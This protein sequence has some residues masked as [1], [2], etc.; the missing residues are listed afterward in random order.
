MRI[1]DILQLGLSNLWRTKLRTML[2]TLGV[3]IGI[4]A[5]ISMVSF[6]T[7]MQKNVTS[8]FYDND[9][10]TSLRVLPMK[11]DINRALSGDV[12]SAMGAM[13][14]SRTIDDSVLC[15]LGNMPEVSIVYPEISFSVKLRY[16][17][18]EIRTELRALPQAMGQYPPHKEMGWGAFFSSDS[19]LEII[20]SERQLHNLKIHLPD[21]PLNVA[22]TDT[23]MVYTILPSDSLLGSELEAVTLVLDAE[24]IAENP[25]IG[26]VQPPFREQVTRLKIRGIKKSA[27]GF[28]RPQIENTALIPIGAEK[29]VPRFEFS[30]M[31]TLLGN[32]GQKNKGYT[33]L[34]VRVHDLRQLSVVRKRVEE[35]GF[36]VIALADQLEEIKRGFIFLDT[37]LGAIGAIALIVAALGIINTMVMSIL[38][39]TREIGIMKAVGGSE[40][41]IKGIFFIE[42]AF[43]G[44]FGGVFG[45]L[46]G[47]GVTRIANIIAN[48]YMVRQGATGHVEL[49]Y[50]PLWLVAGAIAFAIAVSLLAGLY[51]AMRAAR[52]NPVEALRHD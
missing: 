47:W 49:F 48:M 10:F 27:D 17:G 52:V 18:Q 38:E 12:G 5:L 28:E 29:K 45:V 7:G 36:G 46:L 26:M 33:A 44:V 42:A 20:V 13:K 14:S 16:R 24:K 19:A 32:M 4:G 8:I 15:A 37:A 23:G 31:W 41:Q 34:Y 25:L 22:R 30:S 39:R 51:P 40:G 1:S 21:G 11:I 35:M 3:I 9:L 2:T 6:G 43:I 50:L